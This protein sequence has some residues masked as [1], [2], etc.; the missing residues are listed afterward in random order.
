[1][2]NQPEGPGKVITPH[3]YYLRG[4]HRTGSEVRAHS[5][6]DYEEEVMNCRALG[7][8]EPSKREFFR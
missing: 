5:L 1:M 4:C 8:N 2:L 3:F 6:E 7:I